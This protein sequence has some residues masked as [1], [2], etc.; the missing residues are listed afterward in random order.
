MEVVQ[1][2]ESMEE[3]FML[4][5]EMNNEIKRTSGASFTGRG[6]TINRGHEVRMAP[7]QHER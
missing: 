7:K 2:K 4:L 6:E 1:P 3:R 5:S